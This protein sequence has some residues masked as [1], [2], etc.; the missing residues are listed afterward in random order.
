M[1]SEDLVAMLTEYDVTYV[2]GDPFK[3]EDWQR[4]GVENAYRIVV[5]ARNNASGAGL[6]VSYL[7][8]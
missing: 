6:G 8:N 5:L 1:L 7:A 2:P 3:W 4:A